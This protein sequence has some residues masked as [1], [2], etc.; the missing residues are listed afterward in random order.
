MELIK[1]NLVGRENSGKLIPGKVF[2]DPVEEKEKA[3]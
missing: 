1:E 2:T 3:T